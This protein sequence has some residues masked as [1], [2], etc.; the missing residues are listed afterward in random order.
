MEGGIPVARLQ[1]TGDE[2][3]GGAAHRLY[4][5]ARLGRHLLTLCAAAGLW[6]PAA[7]EVALFVEARPELSA[8]AL[9][10][11]EDGAV[12]L[13][14][15][16]PREL[17]DP[18]VSGRLLSRLQAADGVVAVGG[19]AAAW[20]ARELDGARVHLAGGLSRVP[21]ATLKARGWG[22]S[23]PFP[24]G[25]FLDLARAEGWKR[26]GVL[27]TPG[28]EGL[29]PAVRAAAAARGVAVVLRAAAGRQD[30]PAAAQ[31]LAKECEALWLLGDPALTA[32]A[33]FDYLLE[34]SLSRRL[35]LLAPDAEAVT[36][37]AYAA[38]EPDLKA[39]ALRAAEVAKAAHGDAG[40]PPGRLVFDG[41][42]AGRLRVNEVLKR[43]WSATP[44]GSR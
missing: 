35:P 11:P 33:G 40:W 4:R 19:D 42:P 9:G 17:A 14:R 6:R 15:F 32:G 2:R 7:A 27:Y 30:I 34:L 16:E 36:A 39:V 8:A 12:R 44:G 5:A 22:G 29:L 20:A 26:V 41:A 10:V 38:W 21:G 25:A 43:R 24:A 31:A 18:I 13:R 1:D 37:G 3:Q 23:L 28:Y